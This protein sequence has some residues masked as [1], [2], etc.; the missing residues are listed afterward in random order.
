MRKLS[1][2]D[3]IDTF[4]HVQKGIQDNLAEC[5]NLNMAFLTAVYIFH[6]LTPVRHLYRDSI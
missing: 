3:M 2:I 6:D 1:L 4:E 5:K